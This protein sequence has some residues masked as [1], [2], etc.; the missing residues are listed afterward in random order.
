MQ[1]SDVSKFLA[2]W[3]HCFGSFREEGVVGYLVGTRFVLTFLLTA[4]PRRLECAYNKIPEILE[5]EVLL[6]RPLGQASKKLRRFCPVLG[7]GIWPDR[8]H[9]CLNPSHSTMPDLWLSKG[10]DSPPPFFF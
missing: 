7:V 10:K 6:R 1:A 4:C 3:L 5:S 8:F 2:A 9:L